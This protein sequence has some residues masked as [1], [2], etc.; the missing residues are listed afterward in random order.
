MAADAA[1]TATRRDYSADYAVLDLLDALV[2]KSLLIVDRSSGRTRF[3][4]LETIRQ[5]VE[6]QL[7]ARREA[8]EVRSTHAG[9][10]ASREADQPSPV[11]DARLSTPEFAWVYPVH[12][13]VTSRTRYLTQPAGHIRRISADC[14]VFA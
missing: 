4:M 11:G 9:Y 6:E 7:G 2:R 12:G 3:S 14:N 13:L 5:F 10:F 1:R 8:S